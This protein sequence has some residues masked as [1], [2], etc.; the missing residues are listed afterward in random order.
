MAGTSTIQPSGAESQPELVRL[1]DGS[2]VTIRPIRAED[3][4]A[5]RNFLGDLSDEARRLRFFSGAVDLERAAH[6]GVEHGHGRVGLVVHD[7]Q[8]VLVGHAL[9]VRIDDRRAEVALAVADHVQNRG[10][11]TLLIERLAVIAEA[12]GITRFVAEVLPEN[13]AMLDVFQEGFE[14]SVRMR[15]GTDAVEFPVAAWRGA[16]RR[17]GDGRPPH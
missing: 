15:G 16:Q 3:E 11:A 4:G 14:A 13:R 17:F 5:L 6:G 9:Y 12:S 8:G 1:R 2:R 10:L 7:A